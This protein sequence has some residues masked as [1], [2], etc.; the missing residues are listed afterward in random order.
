MIYC[1]ILE[2]G[3]GTVNLVTLKW[4]KGL[5]GKTVRQ[6]TIIGVLLY[7]LIMRFLFSCEECGETFTQPYLLKRH[8]Q[9]QHGVSFNTCTHE[10]CGQKFPGKFSVSRMQAEKIWFDISFEMEMVFL[11]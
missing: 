7:V 5:I 4:G 9:K 6:E 2:K 1:S 8:Q 3:K 11:D 10:K